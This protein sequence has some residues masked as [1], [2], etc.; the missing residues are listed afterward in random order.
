MFYLYFTKFHTYLEKL[1]VLDHLR[2][3]LTPDVLQLL[4]SVHVFPPYHI[5]P[6][7]LGRSLQ[8]PP[9]SRPAKC[10]AARLV[11]GLRRTDHISPALASLGWE[12]VENMVAGHDCTNVYKA[13]TSQRCPVALRDMFQKRSDVSTRSTVEPPTLAISNCRN[14]GSHRPARGSSTELCAR[15]ISYHPLWKPLHLGARL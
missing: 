15:G 4:V 7:R 12:R 11:T 8:V 2:H 3:H 5:L 1:G 13:L 10:F 9:E 6:I 14:A